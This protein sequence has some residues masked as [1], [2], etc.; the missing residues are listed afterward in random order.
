MRAEDHKVL[1]TTALSVP[2]L[3]SLF[4]HSAELLVSLNV[5]DSRTYSWPGQLYHATNLDILLICWRTIDT[6]QKK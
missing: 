5:S 3:L 1:H 4:G 2:V 6:G